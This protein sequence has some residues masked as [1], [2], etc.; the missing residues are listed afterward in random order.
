MKIPRNFPHR[1]K[2]R[3]F[4]AIPT[5]MAV[6]GFALDTSARQ[7][8]N[9]SLLLRPLIRRLRLRLGYF[10]PAKCEQEF[11]FAFCLF[12][13]FGFALDTSARQNANNSLL[14]RFAYSSS[15]ASP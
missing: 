6:F 9:N 14:L 3:P 10:R 2:P 5:E 7:N 13:V 8:A 15:L 11:A 1:K 4:S 12:V